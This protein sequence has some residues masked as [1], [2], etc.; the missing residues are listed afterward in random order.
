MF[1]ADADQRT[2]AGHVMRCIT[3]AAEFVSRGIPSALL[4]CELPA[5]LAARCELF[6]VKSTPR[7]HTLS[8]PRVIDEIT[9][10][11]PRLVVLDSYRLSDSV[12]CGLYELLAP[13]LVIDDN[14]E[15]MPYGASFILNQ[16]LHAQ[17]GLY[18]DLPS[19][20]ICLMGPTYA[21]IRSEIASQLPTAPIHERARRVAIAI[22]GTD[23]MELSQTLSQALTAAGIDVV[24][25]AGLLSSDGPASPLNVAQ[26]FADS[27][28][29]VVGA[30]SSLWE[31]ACLGTPAVGLIVAENQAEIGR[32]VEAAGS[33]IAFDARTRF[34]VDRVV[35]AISYL[36]SDDAALT[37]MSTAGSALVDRHGAVRVADA[38]M[39]RVTDGQ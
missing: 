30:G 11:C 14:C 27:A 6:G 3:L 22:G 5:A 37:A 38:V 24:C 19:W 12:T 31:L 32:S 8:D 10:L 13:V 16:N 26:L 33:G 28:M 15:T 4:S 23:S 1:V 39:P 2:G 25:P 21:L 36:L 18:G 29:A 34:E 7:R 35:E 9:A 20:A 17:E